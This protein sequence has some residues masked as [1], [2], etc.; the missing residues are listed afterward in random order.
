MVGVRFQSVIYSYIE[1]GTH[2][3]KKWER[4]ALRVQ[5]GQERQYYE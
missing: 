1:I 4:D 3:I 5:C 2:L